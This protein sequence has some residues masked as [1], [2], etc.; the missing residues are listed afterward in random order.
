MAHVFYSPLNHTVTILIARVAGA[1]AFL[2]VGPFAQ[3]AKKKQ[4]VAGFIGGPTGGGSKTVSSRATSG[5][6]GMVW[7]RRIAR[8]T[9]M[10]ESDR[11]SEK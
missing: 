1:S 11:S 5:P 3:W 10:G 6:G 9:A 8:G 2:A 7:N 4:V